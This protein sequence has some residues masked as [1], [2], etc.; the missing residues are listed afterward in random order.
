MDDGSPVFYSGQGSHFGWGVYATDIEPV[1][2]QTWEQVSMDCFQGE[3]TE[4]EL[5]W[6]F[7]LLRGAGEEQFEQVAPSEWVIARDAPNEPV[8]ADLLCV[9]VRRWDGKQWVLVA[10]WDGS[11]WS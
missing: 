3:A 11:D 5:S 10:E 4:P 2:D 9:E 1:D 6:C 8:E 7:V